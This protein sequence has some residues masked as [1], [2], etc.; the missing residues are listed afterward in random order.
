M[1]MEIT[2]KGLPD[3]L[4]GRIKDAGLF[5]YTYG[6]Y[7]VFGV[8]LFVGMIFA[9][10]SLLYVETWWHAVLA[11]LFISLVMGQ[12]GFLAH[13]VTHKQICKSDKINIA[14]G[15]TIWG[16]V[17]GMSMVWWEDD[18]NQHHQEPNKI[19]HDT[20]INEQFIF[21]PKQLPYAGKFQKKYILP[22]QHYLFLPF[23]AFMYVSIVIMSFHTVLTSLTRS[24]L[25][26]RMFV[27][28]VLMLT[29]HLFMFG[30]V[31]WALPPLHAII[32]LL[33]VHF[34]GGLS[35]GLAFAPN[36]KGELILGEDEEVT[37]F[38][39]IESTRN[40]TPSLFN[41]FVLGSLNYQIEHHLFPRLPR[42]HL[43]KAR[44]IIKQYC[45]ENN[46]TYHETTLIGS[47]IEI[48]KSLREN[49]EFAKSGQ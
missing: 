31:F 36:H 29:H 33:I 4:R 40:I 48:L 14:V 30:F 5:R 24:P 39:Q 23:S 28:L 2:I 8:I 13:D 17:L 49:A 12:F 27:E 35:M 42:P 1:S 3:E 20:Q 38:T 32:V 34:I 9:Y 6:Y 19:N 21:S 43:P 22:I 47:Y 7:V 16:L 25:R 41:D 18:H 45:M 44:T 15:E 10:A 46:I 11:G 26:P 37:F